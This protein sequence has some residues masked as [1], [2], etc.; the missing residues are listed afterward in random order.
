MNQLLILA[1]SLFLFNSEFRQNSTSNSAPSEL[2]NF[3]SIS[4]CT[5]KEFKLYGKVQY[6]ESFPD[7][8]IQF[9][10]SFPDLRVQFVE[11]FPDHCGKWQVVS[12]F[13][14]IKVQVVESFPDIK[15]QVVNSF[16]GK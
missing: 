13:P 11:S 4:D 7:I 8:K 6:V 2:E 3:S 9:V 15:V 12:S 1:L 10:N 5:W 16:P 14:D